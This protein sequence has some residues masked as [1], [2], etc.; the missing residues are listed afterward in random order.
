MKLNFPILSK[1]VDVLEGADHRPTL[2]TLMEDDA[3]IVV[4]LAEGFHGELVR[5]VLKQVKRLRLLSYP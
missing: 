1:P 5:S 4:F 3:S 2:V